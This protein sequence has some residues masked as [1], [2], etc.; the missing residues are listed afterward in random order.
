VMRPGAE[1]ATTSRSRDILPWETATAAPI[2]FL[3]YGVTAGWSGGVMGITLT[4]LA[5]H[6]PF[7]QLIEDQAAA[8]TDGHQFAYFRA[9]PCWFARRTRCRG[10]GT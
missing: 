4:A 9:N 7:R 3:G 6:A 8:G 1:S 5:A 10:Q 2:I